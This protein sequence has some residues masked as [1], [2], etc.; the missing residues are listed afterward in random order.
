MSDF[1]KVKKLIDEE[2]GN[3]K[4]L[5]RNL[6]QKKIAYEQ[7]R[8]DVQKQQL[9]SIAPT[10]ALDI[11]AYSNKVNE[12]L[13][14]L[15]N[16]ILISPSNDTVRELRGV[17]NGVKSK[18]DEMD[19]QQIRM[20]LDELY[21]FAKMITVLVSIEPLDKKKAEAEEAAEAAVSSSNV[22]TTTA[23]ENKNMGK[24]ENILKDIASKFSPYEN[25]REKSNQK[26]KQMISLILDFININGKKYGF[27][28]PQT[29]V[30][31]SSRELKDARKRLEDIAN[32]LVQR[33]ITGYEEE[34][35]QPMS[36]RYFEYS[37]APYGAEKEEVTKS[38][39]VERE[40][41][42]KNVTR[43]NEAKRDYKKNKS[44]ITVINKALKTANEE[45][46][47]ELEE[48]KE[49]LIE[50]NKQLSGVIAAYEKPVY[51]E[52]EEEVV[53]EPKK[54][55]KISR[56]SFGQYLSKI[57]NYEALTDLLREAYEVR[58]VRDAIDKAYADYLGSPLNI[59]EYIETEIKKET[60]GEGFKKMKGKGITKAKFMKKYK[61]KDL[62]K[63]LYSMVKEKYPNLKKVSDK[64]LKE[65]F[66]EL[67]EKE[68]HIV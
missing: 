43:Y 58:T 30:E 36:T 54:E 66:N 14:S 50:K 25:V 52:E 5:M 40:V 55:K 59:K 68:K 33:E 64:K 20:K 61:E 48:E 46:A 45:R 39:I 7:Y 41:K 11:G 2:I 19:K 35:T 28:Y 22:T 29:F 10:T 21:M 38:E 18:F 16:E 63:K 42:T 34:E 3:V 57:E 4:S 32:K 26:L 27:R 9:G 1:S 23:I 67:Y 37:T 49:L 65:A 56:S 51:K 47:A 17:L 15:Y 44:R 60:L 12:E 13:D 6:L 8:E 24:L 53:E 62:K 31:I